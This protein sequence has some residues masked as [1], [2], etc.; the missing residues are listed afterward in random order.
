MLLFD[1]YIVLL[2]EN[3]FGEKKIFADFFRKLKK[4]V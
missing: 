2:Y 3:V 4:Q 1:P